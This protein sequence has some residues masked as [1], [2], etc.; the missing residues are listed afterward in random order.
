[1][2][3]TDKTLENIKKQYLIDSSICLN[4]GSS[5]IEGRFVNVDCGSAWQSIECMECNSSWDDVYKLNDVDNIKIR[6]E[7]L[8]GINDG[9]EKEKTDK[10]MDI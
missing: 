3:Y 8:R 9:M 4:C 1:M 7:H 2:K 10:G 5:D 6:N